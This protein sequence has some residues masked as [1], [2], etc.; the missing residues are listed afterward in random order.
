MIRKLHL[1]ASLADRSRAAFAAEVLGCLVLHSLGPRW[2]SV[3][4]SLWRDL[5]LGLRAAVESPVLRELVYPLAKLVA[6]LEQALASEATQALEQAGTVAVGGVAVGGVAAEADDAYGRGAA[7]NRFSLSVSCGAVDYI[8]RRKASAEVEPGHPSASRG[9][10]AQSRSGRP[11]QAAAVEVTF[12]QAFCC[13]PNVS[14]SVATDSLSRTGSNNNGATHSVSAFAAAPALPSGVT[15]QSVDRRG[16][17]LVARGAPQLSVAWT[18]SSPTIVGDRRDQRARWCRRWL[19]ICRVG[20]LPFPHTH[21]R[22][23]ATPP[24]PPCPPALH[25]HRSTP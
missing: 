4:G 18:A 3:G 17:V 22:T 16:F 5:K 11:Q 25:R 1:A 15:V 10:A 6:M 9:R 8:E 2:L 24:T 12:P 14:V 21:T 20:A 7:N 13:A 19:G 23:H